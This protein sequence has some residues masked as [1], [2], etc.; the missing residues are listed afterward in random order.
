VNGLGFKTSRCCWRT[1]E[2][3]WTRLLTLVTNSSFNLM[4]TARDS[5]DRHRFRALLMV[6][7]SP[8]LKCFP[9]SFK[10]CAQILDLVRL[11]LNFPGRDFH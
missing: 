11:G 6:G 3:M 2:I 1:S 4:S 5:F 9:A 8:D 7:Q 10:C